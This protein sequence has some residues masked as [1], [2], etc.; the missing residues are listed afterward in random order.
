MGAPGE[1]V[2]INMPF[3]VNDDNNEWFTSFIAAFQ[4]R[5]H[6]PSSPRLRARSN[7]SSS[8]SSPSLVASSSSSAACA[9]ISTP[10]DPS[11]ISAPS[12][13]G[14]SS[15]TPSSPRQVL[16]PSRSRSGSSGSLSIKLPLGRDIDHPRL[17]RAGY[18]YDD[19]DLFPGFEQFTLR[20]GSRGD[21]GRYWFHLRM[22]SEEVRPQHKKNLST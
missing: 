21:K 19:G 10:S 6:T 1:I 4:R 16:S 15:A 17:S 14:H 5:F 20:P 13:G 7:T 12:Q 22:D 3:S 18:S 8:L 2:Y 9:G 11:A